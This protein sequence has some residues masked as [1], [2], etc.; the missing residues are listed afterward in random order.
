MTERNPKF[1][2][3]EEAKINCNACGGTLRPVEEFVL[4]FKDE[5]TK[6]LGHEPKFI[7]KKWVC[8]YCGLIYDPDFVNTGIKI[9]WAD[10]LRKYYEELKGGLK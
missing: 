10:A 9:E 4:A 1:T 8:S 5:F 3:P 2:M 7:E 6:A